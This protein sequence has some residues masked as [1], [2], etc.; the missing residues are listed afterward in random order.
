MV[1]ELYALGYRGHDLEDEVARLTGLPL[2]DL[3]LLIGIE[4]GTIRGDTVP[5]V[6]RETITDFAQHMHRRLQERGLSSP[7][8]RQ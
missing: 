7:Y 3:R 1:K 4:L 6:G 2:P 8:T 5:P